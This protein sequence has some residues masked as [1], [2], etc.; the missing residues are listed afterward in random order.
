MFEETG[1]DAIMIGRAAMRDPT[2]FGRIDHYLENGNLQPELSV[3]EKIVLA[4]E[5]SR[6]VIERFGEKGCID[7]EGGAVHCLRRSEYSS[8]KRMGD[9]DVIANFDGKQECLLRDKK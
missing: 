4:L 7:D 6:L 2:I 3:E 8:A 1:C 5:H 9:H